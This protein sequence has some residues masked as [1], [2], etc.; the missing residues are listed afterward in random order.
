MSYS[1]QSICYETSDAALNAFK[2]S[3]PSVSPQAVA[4]LEGVPTIDSFGRISYA[5]H[6]L[7]LANGAVKTQAG[8]VQ[9]QSCQVPLMDQYPVQTILMIVGLFF[10]FAKGFSTG[11][12]P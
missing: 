11:F 10:A 3:F 5:I 12:R 7:S 6:T 8:S 4:S 9:L 1:Y 2:L